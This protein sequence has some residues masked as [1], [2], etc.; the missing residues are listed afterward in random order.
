LTFRRLSDASIST[1]ADAAVR[2]LFADPA[3][4][5]DWAHRWRRRLAED[6]GDAGDRVA[7][8]R[9]AGPAFIPRNH[10][11]KEA[12]SAA[13][14]NGEFA[15]F[16]RLLTVLSRPYEDQPDFG[17]YANPPRPDQVVRQTFC[18]T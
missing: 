15:P 16:E 10:L 2:S 3:A 13:V 14:N 4:Y 7:A 11:V 1:D 6:G 8:M 9:V 17:R 5:D 18:G 12:L